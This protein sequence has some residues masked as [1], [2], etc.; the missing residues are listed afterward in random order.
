MGQEIGLPSVAVPGV[1]EA[2]GERF[3]IDLALTLWQVLDVGDIAVVRQSAILVIDKVEVAEVGVHL[4][5]IGEVV[6]EKAIAQQFVA[7]RVVIATAVNVVELSTD[8]DTFAKVECH[9]PFEPIHFVLTGSP[10]GIGHLGIGH[11]R[12]VEPCVCRGGDI[13][14]VGIREDKVS[15]LFAFT[16]NL[17]L[18]RR[19][20]IGQI[21]RCQGV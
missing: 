17:C 4:V 1:S 9:H 19:A 3:T 2:H 5:A 11:F 6:A 20:D 15:C 8:I 7:I 21:A 16:E 13:G 10:C 18:E 12:V 14:V